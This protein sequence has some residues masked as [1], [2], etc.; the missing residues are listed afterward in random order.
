[1]RVLIAGCGYVGIELARALALERGNRV[2]GLR[3]SK[4][5]MPAGV[6]PIVADLARVPTPKELPDGLDAV[7]YTVGADGHT[8]EQYEAAYVTG[9][10]NLAQALRA[11]GGFPP[12]LVVVTSTAVYGQNDGEWVDEHSP[13]EPREFSGRTLLR[14]EALARSLAREVVA[15]RFGGI[16]GPGRTR[17]IDSV[18]NGTA[19]LAARPEY[20]NRIHQLDCAGVLA[21]VLRL[22]SPAPTYIGVDDEPADRRA[23]VEW[24][25]ERIGVTAPKPPEGYGGTAA[26]RARGKRCSNRLLR[27]SGYVFRFPTFREGYTNLLERF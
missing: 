1:V 5:D 14:S 18:R 9:L 15:V 26:G 25:A 22:P 2:W 19:T 8:P 20:T 11:A 16:Y 17:F 6:R 10:A 21:H 13:T 27:E 3:R 12:R 24:I 4:T 7:V 23:V